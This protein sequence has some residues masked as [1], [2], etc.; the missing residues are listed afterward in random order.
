MHARGCTVACTAAVRCA[1]ALARLCL[2]WDVKH[3][4]CLHYRLAASVLQTAK[5]TLVSNRTP[6]PLSQA[7]RQ[8]LSRERTGNGGPRQRRRRRERDLRRGRRPDVEELVEDLG[9]R[10]LV[11]RVVEEALQQKRLDRE[12]V[13][14]EVPEAVTPPDASATTA[15]RS[16]TTRRRRR[17]GST[18]RRRPR[19]YDARRRLKSE[20]LLR[21]RPTEDFTRQW[22]GQSSDSHQL[23]DDFGR[24]LP[25]ATAE[26]P[27]GFPVRQK[28][29]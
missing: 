11:E 7:P 19:I 12:V 3:A 9:R 2:H 5:Q 24:V 22:R 21:H 15:G 23:L 6:P 18:G 25:S 26:M 8:Y 27:T 29:T 1:S 16:R 4:V 13:D 17:C 14:V 28:S 20:K 10:R